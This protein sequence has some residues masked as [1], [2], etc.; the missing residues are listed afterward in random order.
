MCI[1]DRN[2]AC[3]HRNSY[4]VVIFT[5]R[6]AC[7]SFVSRN[8]V[9][10][11]FLENVHQSTTLTPRTWIVQVI[12]ENFSRSRRR[13]I[14]NLLRSFYETARISSTFWNWKLF[15]CTAV[16]GRPARNRTAK[17]HFL[18]KRG[19]YF[20]FICHGGRRDVQSRIKSSDF[21]LAGP[22]QFANFLQLTHA[23]DKLFAIRA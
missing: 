1:R 4:S 18:L 3:Q 22:K 19:L 10:V 2:W 7:C 6:Y 17:I 13:L 15:L 20:I 23:A 11:D 5:P 21:F 8:Y 9:E 12:A 16:D 14:R